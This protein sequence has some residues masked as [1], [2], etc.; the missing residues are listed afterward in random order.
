M[1]DVAKNAVKLALII[2]MILCLVSG[3]V[4]GVCYALFSK[5]ISDTIDPTVASMSTAL[6]AVNGNTLG[7][8]YTSGQKVIIYAN[9]TATSQ[10]VAIQNTSDI[11][12]VMRASVQVVWENADGTQVSVAEPGTYT[13]TPIDTT[14]GTGILASYSGWTLVETGY[15][16]Y[17]SIVAADET[18]P[19][20]TAEAQN[21]TSV[22]T[23]ATQMR[24]KIMVEVMQSVGNHFVGEWAIDDRWVATPGMGSTTAVDGTPLGSYSASMSAVLKPDSGTTSGWSVMTAG[25][26]YTLDNSFMIPINDNT[27]VGTAY[28][29]PILSGGADTRDYLRIYNND[30]KYVFVGLRLS[31]ALMVQSS[32]TDQEGQPVYGDTWNNASNVTGAS[33]ITTSIN[34]HDNWVSGYDATTVNTF[35]LTD[36]QHYGFI[37][38]KL[39]APG[40]SVGALAASVTLGGVTSDTS[41]VLRNGHYAIRVIVE[42]FCVESSIALGTSA[43]GEY[44]Y[45][46]SIN[47]AINY[48]NDSSKIMVNCANENITAT[49]EGPEL[50]A[51]QALA[52]NQLLSSVDSSGKTLQE[53]LTTQYSVWLKNIFGLT[54][55]DMVDGDTFE[56][57]P[58][59]GSI[60]PEA[61]SE[62]VMSRSNEPNEVAKTLS[63]RDE[64]TNSLA[65]MNEMKELVPNTVQNTGGVG[66]EN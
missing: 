9:S 39:L 28:E 57:G 45:S 38:G 17:N 15:Y 21:V 42:V 63:V 22:P 53:R 30:S 26:S 61:I 32:T 4:V 2:A 51:Q 6:Y 5:S 19:F 50:S 43:Q 52:K 49:E 10:S 56:G 8:Q 41:S 29:M 40:E 35:T 46:D 18:V 62:E 13:I 27:A 34:L 14:A 25:T 7:T 24:V 59:A 58:V 20:I 66:Y 47:F 11:S 1:T 31:T 64:D 12:V 36:G 54:S 65:I 48:G 33:S 23:D 16:Y 60:E 55:D 3:T 37:Y 44:Q